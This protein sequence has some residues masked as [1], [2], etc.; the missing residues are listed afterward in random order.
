MRF[1]PVTVHLDSLE[2]TVNSALINVSIRHVSMEVYVWMEVTT[3]SVTA[4]VVDS[5]EYTVRPSCLFVGQSLVTMMQHLKSQLTAIF[6]T[7]LLDT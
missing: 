6:V 1:T 5:R 3:T 2:T 7:A 4:W